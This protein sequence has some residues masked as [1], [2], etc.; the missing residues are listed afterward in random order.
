LA[1]SRAEHIEKLGKTSGVG[2]QL[3]GRRLH[4]LTCFYLGEFMAR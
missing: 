4:G 3:L 2:V 1:L